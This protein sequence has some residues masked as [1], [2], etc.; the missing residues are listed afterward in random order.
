MTWAIKRTKRYY[1]Q[2]N[3]IYS[4]NYNLI[5]RSYLCRSEFIEEHKRVYSLHFIQRDKT[6]KQFQKSKNFDTN[7]STW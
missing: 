6:L 4:Q 7:Q 5:F 3:T 1:Q 2:I